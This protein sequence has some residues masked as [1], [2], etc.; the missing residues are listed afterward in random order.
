VREQQQVV[1]PSAHL[2]RGNPY[3]LQRLPVG[4][5]LSRS[6]EA[7][8]RLAQHQCKRSLDLVSRLAQE[9]AIPGLRRLQARQE[10]IE[11][12]G[13]PVH[14]VSRLVDRHP[15]VQRVGCDVSHCVGQ[16]TNG[17]KGAASQQVPACKAQEQHD[18]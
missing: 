17:R 3:P 10:P 11:L 13:E 8:V 14:F 9:P 5:A 4:F 2:L 18:G 15:L 12:L 1:N 7:Q 16:R 6:I